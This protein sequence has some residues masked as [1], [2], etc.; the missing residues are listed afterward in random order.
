M[1]G[2]PMGGQRESN[3]A[4]SKCPFAPM[5]QN[6]TTAAVFYHNIAKILHK[7]DCSMILA[8]SNAMLQACYKHAFESHFTS[9]C[10]IWLLC[11][12][13]SALSVEGSLVARGQLASPEQAQIFV[14]FSLSPSQSQNIRAT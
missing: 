11:Q 14:S 5:L 8:N 6:V 3:L 9:S 2:Q 13:R 7:L 12:H 4:M 1:K 10:N